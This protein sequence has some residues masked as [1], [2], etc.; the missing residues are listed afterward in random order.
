VYVYSA[1]ELQLMDKGYKIWHNYTSQ[2]GDSYRILFVVLDACSL[3]EDYPNFV[4]H[5][6]TYVV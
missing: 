2:V 5:A 4:N 3:R 6:N 1:T